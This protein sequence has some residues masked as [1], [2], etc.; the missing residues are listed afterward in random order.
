MT[1]EYRAEGGAV[2]PL[3]VHTVVISLSHL[4]KVTL[5]TVRHELLEKVIKKVIPAEYLDER[6][7]YHLNPAGRFLSAGPMVCSCPSLACSA[8][9]VVCFRLHSKH[10]TI[11][12]AYPQGDAGLTGRKII[13]DTYGG[14][15]AHGGGSFSGKVWIAG[16]AY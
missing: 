12:F 1:V 2:V 10:C 6:T 3:R 7:V 13:V 15:G 16:D 14:W 11:S 4:P 9:R 5:E 8:F